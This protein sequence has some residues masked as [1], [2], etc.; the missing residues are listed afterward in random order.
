MRARGSGCRQLHVRDRRHR[1]FTISADPGRDAGRQPVQDLRRLRSGAHLHPRHLLQRRRRRRCSPG[2]LSRD[3]RRGRPGPT[4]STSGTCRP[5]RT[6][7]SASPASYLRH[8]QGHPARSAPT[9]PVP[10]STATGRPGLYLHRLSGFQFTD[11]EASV[12]TGLL[13]R[14]LGETVGGYAIT[15]G[16]PRRRLRN[17]TISFTGRLADITTGHPRRSRRRHQTKVYGRHDPGLYLHRQRL[18]VQ[19]RRGLGPQRRCSARAAGENVGQPTPS[20]RGPSPRLRTTR[21]ASPAAR[22]STSPRPPCRSTPTRPPRPTA[23]PTRPSTYTF[24]GFSAPT[25]RPRSSITGSRLCRGPRRDRRRRP[26][27]ITAPPATR[28]PQL[29]VRR[30]A[31]RDLRHQPPATLSV[32]PDANQSKTYGAADP[33]FTYTHSGFATA[34]TTAVTSPA[35]LRPRR[36][37]STVAGGP[38]RSRASGQPVA[39]TNYTLPDFTTGDLRDHPGHLVGHRRPGLQDL[40][41]RRPGV[42]LHLQRLPVLRRRSYGITGAGARDLR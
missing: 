27:T 37:A 14:D 35:P 17:Y 20:T 42:H 25:T 10:R 8:H 38:T 31:H 13:A 33:M 6:T 30:P 41:R 4:P 22:P 2:A 28:S 15:P 40:R 32:T 9:R 16:S 24:S 3:R 23:T 36:P 26:Y 34:T 11:N 19:R 5:D 7:R 1:R 21:S 12:L 18:P 39:G 29:H